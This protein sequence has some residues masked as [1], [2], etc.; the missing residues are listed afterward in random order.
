MSRRIAHPFT[1]IFELIAHLNR[2]D[3][4]F[5]RLTTESVDLAPVGADLGFIRKREGAGAVL[6]EEE[7]PERFLA[8]QMFE[9]APAWYP[10]S[11]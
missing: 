6:V 3:Q 5:V 8:V 1:K 7:L 10:F 9:A 2:V 4:D 11:K